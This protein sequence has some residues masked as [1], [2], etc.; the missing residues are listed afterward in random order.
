MTK[1]DITAANEALA[2]HNIRTEY[3]KHGLVDAMAMCQA[4][5][6]VDT[7]EAYNRVKMLCEEQSHERNQI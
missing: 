6:G 2:I 7:V 3:A 4:L 1:Q 5:M